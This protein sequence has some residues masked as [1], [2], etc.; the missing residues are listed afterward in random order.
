MS[1]TKISFVGK[2]IQ[3]CQLHNP[4]QHRRLLALVFYFILVFCIMHFWRI[5]RHCNTVIIVICVSLSYSYYMH[6][7]VTTTGSTV[8]GNFSATEFSP[9]QITFTSQTE[10]FTR[11]TEA[12][13]TALWFNCHDINAVIIARH[14]P[15]WLISKSANRPV[16]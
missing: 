14:F 11:N 7:W 10:S 3:Y 13:S 2:E 9:C 4:R 1:V 15:R 6:K 12:L 16:V 8:P 5:A